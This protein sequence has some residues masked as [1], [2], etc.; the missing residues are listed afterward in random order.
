MTDKTVKKK[1]QTAR[2]TTAAAEATKQSSTT[3]GKTKGSSTSKKAVTA[4][5]TP[6]RAK[7]QADKSNTGKASAR[8][9][10]P[11]R[12][13][14]ARAAT[15]KVSTAQVSK[16]TDKKPKNE[17]KDSGLLSFFS[18]M[19]KSQ[20]DHDQAQE[21]I[22][23]DFTQRVE[24]SF[25]HFHEE[26]DERERLLEKKLKQAEQE[27]ER[28][29]RRVKW[30]SVPIGLIAISSLIYIFYVVHVMERSMTSMSADMQQISSHIVTMSEDTRFMAGSMGNMDYNMGAMRHTMA[31]I[32]KAA[33]D[34]QPMMNM[35][36]RFS[37][38]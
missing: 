27:Q 10:A 11:K 9:T 4:R 1:V 13:A 28:E 20:V 37:P 34:A 21:K 38:F 2:K 35:I 26:F 17:K 19:H 36:R 31:P 15:K 29:I 22:I 18:K 16:E 5:K 7:K 25:K 6:V 8:K 32:G 23:A 14:S 33:H 3:A 30:V 12:A 24:A